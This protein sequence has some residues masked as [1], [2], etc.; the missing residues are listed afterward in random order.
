MNVPVTVSIEDAQS[1]LF[2]PGDRPER[3]DKAAASGAD[4]VIVDLED[5][6][7]GDLKE[8]ARQA[9][10]HWLTPDHNVLVRISDPNSADELAICARPGVAG[11]MLPKAEVKTIEVVSL[12]GKPIIALIE[13]ASAVFDLITI[14]RAPGVI[15]LALGALDL[16]LDIGLGPDDH[17]LDGVRLQMAM[18]SRAAGIAPPVN[19]VTSNYTDSAALID[20]IKRARALGFNGKLCI[21]PSQVAPVRAAFAPT[22]E[23][24]EWAQR[25]VGAASQSSAGASSLSGAMID[26]PVVERAMRLLRSSANGAST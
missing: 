20:D 22:A 24:V 18:A 14:A 6:V 25:I 10:H 16:A 3:F 8:A 12:V 1:F 5:A 17:L 13:T 11:I 26:K 23:E 7:A 15:R 9:L 2:V 21:H 19:G 4:F